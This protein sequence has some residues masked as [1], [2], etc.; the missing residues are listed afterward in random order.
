[1]K[2]QKHK[3]KDTEL[4]TTIKV[5]TTLKIIVSVVL[6]LLVLYYFLAV[7]VTKEIDVSGDKGNS[8]S[9]SSNSNNVSNKIL[10][11]NTF[12]QTEE[13]YYV[14]YYDF[15]DED[16]NISSLI[17]NFNDYTVY[18][19]DTSNSLN[20]NYVTEDEMGNNKAKSLDELKVINPTIIKVENDTIVDYYEGVNSIT[21]FL[22]K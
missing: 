1:M 11:V 21:D 6:I 14:Y 16:E 18:K 19:V 4:D 8:T 22:N 7:F 15:N 3:I 12:N 9:E 20:K 5:S 13:I 17:G 2:K 10:A